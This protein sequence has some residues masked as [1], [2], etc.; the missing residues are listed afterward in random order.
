MCAVLTKKYDISGSALIRDTAPLQT[1]VLVVLG[2]FV[3][4]FLMGQYPWEWKHWVITPLDF[5]LLALLVSCALA[6]SVNVSLVACIKQY[7]ASG[8]LEHGPSVTKFC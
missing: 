5:C 7:T 3:D 4:K 8:A 6:S 2:P 1:V